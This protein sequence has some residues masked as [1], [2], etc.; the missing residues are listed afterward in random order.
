[1]VLTDTVDKKFPFALEDIKAWFVR[2]KDGTIIKYSLVHDN[3]N[4]RMT[5]VG[6]TSST[7]PKQ[8]YSAWCD[9]KSTPLPVFAHQGLELRIADSAGAKSAFNT[10][11]EDL[12]IDAGGVITEWSLK[13]LVG[14][15][16]MALANALNPYVDVII[17]EVL[18]LHWADR[19]APDFHPQFWIELADQL[20]NRAA[21]KAPLE[22]YR[23]LINC[24]GGHGRSGTGL[25][26]LMM[27]LSD[28]NALDAITHL[29]AIHC[30]R[31][32][33]SKIQHD[34][35]DAFAQYLGR[36]ANAGEAELVKNYRERFL[37][38]T[39]ET[40]KPYRERLEK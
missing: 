15:N 2:R 40:S 34:Y 10:A 8:S 6:A 39:C 1:M 9:H 32:I 25:V 28:Y 30:P 21:A 7:T 13:P 37:T 31:A 35:I 11:S 4:R 29:R 16:S 22:P 36:E 38:L 3:P 14:G 27:Y 33:E 17:P 18:T 26:C 5:I 24:Q 12:I 23:M 20:L 19:Q